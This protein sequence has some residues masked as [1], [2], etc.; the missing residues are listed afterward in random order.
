MG[1]KKVGQIDVMKK[2]GG[3]CGCLIM[4][5]IGIIVLLALANLN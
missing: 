2:T 1:Y 3:G 5:I 4:L